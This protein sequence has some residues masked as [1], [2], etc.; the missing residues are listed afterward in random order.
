MSAVAETSHNLSRL[1]VRRSRG[2]ATDRASK[3]WPGAIQDRPIQVYDRR[4]W[5]TSCCP[6][7]AETPP[8][9]T[10][11]ASSAISP[12]RLRKRG[13]VT[14]HHR[15][16]A[17]SYWSAPVPLHVDSTGERCPWDAIGDHEAP[18][19]SG[20]FR[21]RAG[22][23]TSVAKLSEDQPSLLAP[24]ACGAAMLALSWWCRTGG[25]RRLRSLATVAWRGLLCDPSRP[26]PSDRP[27]PCNALK[28]RSGIHQ[29][30]AE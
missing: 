11:G 27:T 30:A 29:V 10:G 4:R 17:C 22:R 21:S 28:R 16:G 18:P 15:T 9:R 23:H 5:A 19:I 3:M 26:W 8:V 14:Y 6:K 2:R 24:P 1:I 13:H 20:P 7:R 25:V 12:Q